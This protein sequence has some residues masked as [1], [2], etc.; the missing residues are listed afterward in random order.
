[1]LLLYIADP[2][3]ST[4]QSF[5]KRLWIHRTWKSGN[6]S[7]RLY[8]FLLSIFE[9][10][11]FR[12][13]VGQGR[14]LSFTCEVEIWPSSHSSNIRKRHTAHL[15]S[16]DSILEVREDLFHKLEKVITLLLCVW[17]GDEQCLIVDP[18]Q[19]VLSSSSKRK[20]RALNMKNKEIK[21]IQYQ[22][23]INQLLIF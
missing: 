1:M 21:M 7:R 9:P 4:W 10:I 8:E 18:W 20:L 23:W 19:E 12:V 22:K 2:V 5:F 15:P 13:L 14:S 11:Y 16:R 3:Y 17:Y 6:I